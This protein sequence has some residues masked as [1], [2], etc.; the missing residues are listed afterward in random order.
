MLL[1]TSK[2]SRGSISRGTVI[3]R[4]FEEEKP[5]SKLDKSR[6]KQTQQ[7]LGGYHC[8]R[9]LNRLTANECPQ[10][11]MQFTGVALSSSRLTV[12]ELAER[13]F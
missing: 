7:L 12:S 5:R 2:K 8:N 6:F 3:L 1:K 4:M 9:V 10:I 11:K 13:L